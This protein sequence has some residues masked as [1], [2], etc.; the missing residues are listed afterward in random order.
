M[1]W[2]AP[3]PY[4]ARFSLPL[5]LQIFAI[6]QRDSP[7]ALAY[8]G[9]L[10]PPYVTLDPIA[11]YVFSPKKLQQFPALRI[12]PVSEPFDEETNGALSYIAR[13]F[14]SIGVINQ[15]PDVVGML[16]LK[17]VQ[18]INSILNQYS[19]TSSNV[20][21]FYT[22]LPLTLPFLTPADSVS[23]SP[24]PGGLLTVPLAYGSV[25]KVWVA[26]Q[27]YNEIGQRGNSF[28]ASATLD[29][30]VERTEIQNV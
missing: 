5:C 25:Q 17:Y 1:T 7:A 8:F 18:A 24:T 3:G 30:I 4:A 14:C 13:I 23:S 22:A 6:I 26:S 16:I 19:G 21:D 11:E 27:N 20:A 10:D 2:T 12:T 28:S 15:D 9:T 29:I